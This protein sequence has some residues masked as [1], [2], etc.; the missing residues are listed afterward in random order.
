MK[1]TGDRTANTKKPNVTKSSRLKNEEHTQAP[2][3][4][5]HQREKRIS[6]SSQFVKKVDFNVLTLA[7]VISFAVSIALFY[8]CF[9]F[10]KRWRKK[11]YT[12]Q[13][14]C[15]E[16][17][18][19][20]APPNTTARQCSRNLSNCVSENGD[21]SYEGS[22][23][24]SRSGEEGS[25]ESF[26]RGYS[27]RELRNEA[28]PF[29]FKE[30]LFSKTQ[31]LPVECEYDDYLKQNSM[32][33]VKGMQ[34]DIGEPQSE[35]TPLVNPEEK[36]TMLQTQGANAGNK[37]CPKRSR[38]LEERTCL[39]CSYSANNNCPKMLSDLKACVRTDLKKY[40]DGEGS[41][42]ANWKEIAVYFKIEGIDI[43]HLQTRFAAGKSP[44]EDLLSHLTTKNHTVQE[45]VECLHE[46][47]RLDVKH[48]LLNHLKD[49][50]KVCNPTRRPSC[51]ITY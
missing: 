15:E 41:T 40:L 25:V 22:S 31:S 30:E 2:Q 51:Y 16:G 35:Q 26:T 50:C 9:V 4:T 38:S 34:K 11:K 19:R 3:E 37:R 13:V 47:Q 48:R 32:V 1:Q 7:L 49:G 12:T 46:I 6:N 45:L 21:G 36:Y 8:G 27:T 28:V 14:Q 10:V 39:K 23:A 20:N 43:G 44:T 18:R 24:A 29:E 17:R 33:H 5:T 42:F